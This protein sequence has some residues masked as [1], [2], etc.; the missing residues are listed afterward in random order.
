M[1]SKTRSKADLESRTRSDSV[2][3]IVKKSRGPRK[4][5]SKRSLK[6]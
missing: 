5:E 1:A 6:K 2:I 4:S 3:R